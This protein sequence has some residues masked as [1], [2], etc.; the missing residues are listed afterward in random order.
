MK[1]LTTIRTKKYI[2]LSY[3]SL[4]QM[5]NGKVQKSN[6]VCTSYYGDRGLGLVHVQLY[7]MKFHI[8]F[9]IFSLFLVE[10]DAW[11][12]FAIHLLKKK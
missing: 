9:L 10:L 5:K 1:V 2:P 6:G 11:I 8:C 4:V 3:L 12:I 7:N